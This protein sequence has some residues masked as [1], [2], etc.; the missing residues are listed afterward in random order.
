MAEHDLTRY[1]M[2]K[3]ILMACMTQ[4][5]SPGDSLVPGLEVGDLYLQYVYLRSIMG[6]CKSN[7]VFPLGCLCK[8]MWNKSR[9]AAILFANLP[10]FDARIWPQFSHEDTQVPSL[11]HRNWHVNR[12]F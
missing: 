9:L 5:H 3:G 7:F 4:E 8:C 11:Q 6:D 12:T 1:H 10:C 2:S